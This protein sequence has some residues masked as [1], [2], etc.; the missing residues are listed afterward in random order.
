MTKRQAGE[1][2]PDARDPV[3]T[4]REK[5]PCPDIPAALLSSEH[6]KEYF[7]KTNMIKEFYPERVKS[8]SYEMNAARIIRWDDKE[9]LIVNEKK[10]GSG[11]IR[12]PA[13]SIVFAQVDGSFYLPYYIAARFNL[14]IQHVHRG[15]LLGTG[16][17]IDPGFSGDLL[18][19]VHNLTSDEYVISE[20]EGLIWVEFTKTSYGSNSENRPPPGFKPFEEAK[21]KKDFHYYLDKANKHKPIVSSIPKAVERVSKK[22]TDAE[23]T[24][25]F[26]AS[27]G[28]LTIAALTYAILDLVLSTHNLVSDYPDQ[29]AFRRMQERISRQS[30]EIEAL[31]GEIRATRSHDTGDNS[32]APSSVAE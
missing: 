18:I 11:L 23:R 19:P 16:P 20:D 7:E 15:L 13:N 28:L 1:P 24:T 14:R 30:Q 4:V 32:G 10:D 6:I 3:L 21:T 17:L 9:N 5:D 26:F 8:A 31:Q 25:K 2:L 22:A 27:I 29:E 12:F